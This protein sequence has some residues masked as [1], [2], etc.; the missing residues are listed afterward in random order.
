MFEKNKS[1]LQN[2]S[3][4]TI[5][6]KLRLLNI[7]LLEKH[8]KKEFLTYLIVISEMLNQRDE[9]HEKEIN[10]LLNEYKDELEVVLYLNLKLAKA[11]IS[12]SKKLYHQAVSRYKNLLE[13][14]DITASTKA[15]VYRG[16]SLISNNDKDYILYTKLAIDTFL[17]SGYKKEA[18]SGIV[19]LADFESK[20]DAN[21]ALKQLDYAFKIMSDGSLLDKEYSAS[22]KH[23]K[24]QFLYSRNSFIEALD[25]VEKSCSLRRG[26]LGNEVELHS[27]LSL[28]SIIAHRL[29]Y[30]DK[31]ENYDKE[32]MEVSKLIKDENF[33]LRQEISSCVQQK[34]RIPQDL[35]NKAIATK[36]NHTLCGI[37]MYEYSIMDDENDESMELIDKAILLADKLKDES[38]LSD[39]YMAIG[40][41]NNKYNHIQEAFV[42]YEKSLD[43]NS[44]NSVSYQNCTHMLFENERYHDAK[45]FLKKQIKIIGEL[46]NICFFYAKALLENK[47]Y[48]LAL[49]YF[50]KSNKSI[51]GINTYILEC[52][53]NM[54]S[55]MITDIPILSQSK[56]ISIF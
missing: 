1:F 2:I 10:I 7:E 9:L 19:R 54:D 40:E 16:L 34:N 31:K 39:L 44:L 53:K 17:E 37:Y 51:E 47:E 6:K 41:K 12:A 23:K 13:E 46:P 45:L 25:E 20:T 36:D 21:K 42:A 56:I 49:Q 33:S 27:S 11:N 15:W 52:A 32:L 4:E 8:Q 18:I 14:K 48:P 5:L 24:A 38:L 35:I 28:A 3:D 50:N 22:L 26:L 55:S 29:N 30:D 43:Y